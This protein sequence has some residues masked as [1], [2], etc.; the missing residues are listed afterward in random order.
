MSSKE[1]KYA[2]WAQNYSWNIYYKIPI[3]FHFISLR[4]TFDLYFEMKFLSDNDSTISK[5]APLSTHMKS[6]RA[7]TMKRTVISV[8]DY[9]R[10]DRIVIDRSVVIWKKNEELNPECDVISFI[11]YA[12]VFRCVNGCDWRTCTIDLN[13]FSKKRFVCKMAKNSIAP[14]EGRIQ[15]IGNNHL[16]SCLVDKKFLF[17]SENT[18]VALFFRWFH[19]YHLSFWLQYS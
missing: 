18:N 8:S 6:Y 9:W 7:R 13:A 15:L 5:C 10:L 17:I 14:S 19:Y 2:Y 11:Q 16:L 3:L 4:L 12:A 1:H